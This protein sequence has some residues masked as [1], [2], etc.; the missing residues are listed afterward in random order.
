LPLVKVYCYIHGEHTE[1]KS[2]TQY[3]S[4]HETL[5]ASNEP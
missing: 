3:S 5:S 2:H 1:K 4:G